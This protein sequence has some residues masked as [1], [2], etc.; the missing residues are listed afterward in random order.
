MRHFARDKRQLR[1]ESASISLRHWLRL[2]PPF[3]PLGYEVT[4]HSGL[5]FHHRRR[6]GY[7]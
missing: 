1:A 7:C 4:N 2:T 6:N 3:S 5:G